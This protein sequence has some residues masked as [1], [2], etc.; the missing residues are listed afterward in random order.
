MMW[1]KRLLAALMTKET[2]LK[3]LATLVLVIAVSG[4]GSSSSVR[5]GIDVSWESRPWVEGAGL[6]QLDTGLWE[7][8]FAE[9]CSSEGDEVAQLAARYVTEDAH[10]TSHSDGG[11]PS[12]E[13]AT[14]MLW[15]IRG[16]VCQTTD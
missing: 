7:Q 5:E 8:R 14:E 10:L 4:C 11:M 16:S 3:M 6:T 9:I 2:R 13:Q 15:L 1:R 12:A